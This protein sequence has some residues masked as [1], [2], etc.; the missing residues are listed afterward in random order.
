MKKFSICNYLSIHL[1]G[2]LEKISAL[3][4][5]LF[6]SRMRIWHKHFQR[7]FILY[8]DSTLQAQ[9][10]PPKMLEIGAHLSDTQKQSQ[11]TKTRKNNYQALVLKPNFYSK[12]ILEV[13]DSQILVE[14]ICNKLEKPNNHRKKFQ[15][16][17][18]TKIGVF[19]YGVVHAK[20]K[21]NY[22]K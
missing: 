16:A 15:L 3:P 4:N 18:Q 6:T 22:R 19:A 14:K 20:P 1:F 2:I 11:Y 8:R 9:T 12:I 21:N 7:S 13:R 17:I 10:S 5:T